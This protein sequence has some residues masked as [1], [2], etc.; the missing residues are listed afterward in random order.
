VRQDDFPSLE[1]TLLALLEEYQRA[2][3]REDRQ[4]VQ[5]CRRLV[6][7]AKDHARLVLR[8]PRS[9]EQKKQEKQEMLLW[10]M[11][12]LENPSLFPIW[13]RLRKAAR[14]A[15]PADSQAEPHPPAIC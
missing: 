11:T 14:A 15:P 4:R 13:L 2:A 12:W 5:A 7:A 1:R 6:I 10:L 9:A 3:E 8:N